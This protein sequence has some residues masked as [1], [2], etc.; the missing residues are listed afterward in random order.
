MKLK[1]MVIDALFIA[2]FVLGV[3]VVGNEAYKAFLA[4]TEKIVTAYTV[5]AGDTWYGICDKHYMDNNAEC[6]DEMWAVN[7]RDNGH[8]QLQPGDVVTITNKIY[9]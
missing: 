7:M 1:L 4:P 8:R 5:Q 6:F 3:Y 9:K 2:S